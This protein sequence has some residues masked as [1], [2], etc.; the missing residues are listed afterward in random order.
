MSVTEDQP[1]L[2]ALLSSSSFTIASAGFG[3]SNWRHW[4]EFTFARGAS[5]LKLYTIDADVLVFIKIHSSESLSHG[6][7]RDF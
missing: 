5:L 4:M 2:V 6:A 1:L 3:A 7:Q